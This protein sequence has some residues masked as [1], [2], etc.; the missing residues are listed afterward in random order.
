[1]R[2]GSAVAAVV[3]A[4]LPGR[5]AHADAPRTVCTLT[6]NSPDEQQVFRRHL[7]ADRHRFVELVRRGRADWLDAA[8]RSGLR[9]DVL[10]VSAHFDGSDA[11]YAGGPDQP[12]HTTVADL[13]RLS[14][15][16]AC[17]PLFAQL[18]EVYLFGCNTL[19]P[20]PQG[21]APAELLR[22]LVRAGHTPAQAGQ[23][24]QALAGL[25][26]ESPRDR[27][28]QIFPGVPVIYGFSGAAPLGPVAAA[29]LEGYLRDGGAREVGRGRVSS[30]LLAAFSPFGLAATRGMDA[31]PGLARARA[32]MCRFADRRLSAAGQLA[33]VH[34]L[35]QRPVGE[36]RLAMDRIA[37]L[38]QALDDT[39]RQRPDVAAQL[40]AIARDGAARARLLGY[41]RRL[42]RPAV[43][44]RLFDLAHA[45]GW[46]TDAQ[47]RD[48]LAG[49]LGALHRRRDLGVPEVHLA[50]GLNPD[51]GLDGAA[52]RPTRPAT[53]PDGVAHAA[54]RV[55]LGSAE[56][57]RRM[58]Q[59]LTAAPEADGR[60]AQ[61]YLRHRPVTDAAELRPLVE[62]IAALQPDDRQLLAL[63]ALQHH[64]IDD[65]QAVQRLARLYADS[66]LAAVQ[67]A[68]A[69][70]LIRADR[71]A[72]DAEALMHTLIDKRLPAP[73]GGPLIDLLLDTL[74]RR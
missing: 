65:P 45:L 6:V 35:L 11:F 50:C 60:L 70:I 58:L 67:S 29:R 13:E 28:R 32:D 27:M 8:C 47:R 21:D 14:C 10:V 25:H 2:F 5:A 73:G 1:M 30:R 18:Q 59:A 61:A 19:D 22:S 40:R 55:C 64:R 31:A 3:L 23:A 51:G 46:L 38:L 15:S 39:A 9:C 49:L 12:E 16:A 48:E 72:I 37:R 7:P 26:A 53:P 68:V 4:V 24:L 41:A 20:Q 43:Q 42:D 56:D 52:R 54:L 36:A 57:R 63:E 69:G 74:Q 17:P 44:V 33:F 34:G 71:Q 66:P 62:R